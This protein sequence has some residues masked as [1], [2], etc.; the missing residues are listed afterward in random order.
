MTLNE[1]GLLSVDAWTKTYKKLADKGKIVVSDEQVARSAEKMYGG[2]QNVL[3]SDIVRLVGNVKNAR[4][5]VVAMNSYYSFLQNS[6]KTI[7]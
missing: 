5:T 3:E 2:K 6:F 4:V 1:E 7:S